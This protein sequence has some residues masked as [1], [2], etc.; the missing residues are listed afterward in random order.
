MRYLYKKP[1]IDAKTVGRY[2]DVA[3]NTA[4]AFIADLVEQ[5]VLSEMTGQRRNR[6]YLFHEYIELFSRENS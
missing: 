3:P 5:G 2:L 4:G 1:V 6:L